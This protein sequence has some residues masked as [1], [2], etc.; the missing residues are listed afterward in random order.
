[1]KIR[2]PFNKY[3]W[4][5]DFTNSKYLKLNKTFKFTN[6]KFTKLKRYIKITVPINYTYTLH[7]RAGLR[8]GRGKSKCIGNQFYILKNRIITK[9]KS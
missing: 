9:L 6:D 5:N 7:K 3:T 1:M 8:L 4:I 2:K